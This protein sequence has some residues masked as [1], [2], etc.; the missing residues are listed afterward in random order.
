[1]TVADIVIR[2]R[3]AADRPPAGN[4]ATYQTDEQLVDFI[5]RCLGELRAYRQKSPSDGSWREA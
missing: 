5:I 3:Q 4:D 2:L 1:M